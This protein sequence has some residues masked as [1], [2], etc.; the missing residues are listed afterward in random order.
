MADSTIT[1]TTATTTNTTGLPNATSPWTPST[2]PV[3]ISTGPYSGLNTTAIINALMQVDEQPY[4]DLV[5]KATSYTNEISAYGQISSS[6]SALK[7]AVA[8]LTSTNISTFTTTSSNQN[9]L[10]AT[11]SSKASPGT[12]KIQIS[13][14]AQEEEV[15]SQSYAS[16]TTVAFATGTL[17]VGNGGHSTTINIDRTNNTLTGVRDAINRS[18]TDVSA[19]IVNDGTG[20]RL[21]VS[22]K[23]GGAINGLQ[24]SGTSTGPEGLD[25]GALSYSG[26]DSSTMSLLQTGS[27]ASFTVNGLSITSHTN[28]LTNVLKGVTLNLLSATSP[29]A[30]TLTIGQNAAANSTGM[31]GFVTAYNNTLT[32]LNQ[33]SAQG[34]P[35]YS[36]MTVSSIQNTI[37]TMTTR[38]F[39]GAT[40]ILANFGVNHLKDGTLQID[41]AAMNKAL[42][43]NQLGFNKML[44]AF[45][46]QFNSS[47]AYGVLG[48]LISSTIANVT[49]NLQSNITHIQTQEASL[50]EQL[51]QKQAA[52]QQQY[53][54]LEATIAQLR[55]QS[56]SITPSSSST[57]TASTT[58]PTL[59]TT[60]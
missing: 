41:T 26:A 25:L 2:P 20:Y 24:I 44:D 17:T 14:T 60:A 6:L 37:R 35:L 28:T 38:Y 45:S 10:T 7:T 13:K 18:A 4:N 42:S 56:A 49:G 59:N 11:A 33:L 16:D 54:Q 29:S 22:T 3:S 55:T 36:D 51:N 57:G 1:P 48:N 32:L 12:Y 31:T 40:S 46:Y 30:V 27:D 52:Y 9:I 19:S 39:N 58:I 8:G 15:I 23:N 53:A 47:S 43:Y 5:S 34:Q 21:I 50:S